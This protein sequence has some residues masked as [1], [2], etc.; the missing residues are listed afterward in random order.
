MKRTTLLFLRRDKQILLA[1]K[2]RGF[3][4]DKWNGAGGKL[5]PNETVLQAA[6][7]ECQEE[8]GVTPISQKL[9]GELLFDLPDV[10]HY[11]YV[12]T[13]TAW[14]GE[15]RETEEMRPQWFA[16]NK[17][18]YDQMWPGD[19]IWMPLLLAGKPFK[20]AVTVEKDQVRQHDIKEVKSLKEQV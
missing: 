2:K 11:C 14:Q 1:M 18:P 19:S 4:V 16:E 17:I 12:Y 13:A 7:R 10:E 9:V 20:G 3:G 6:I 8:I 15:L 5:E